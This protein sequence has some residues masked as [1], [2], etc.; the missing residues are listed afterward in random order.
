M[1]IRFFLA[2]MAHNM[3]E[4][5]S[6]EDAF[7]EAALDYD[8]EYAEYEAVRPAYYHPEQVGVVLEPEKSIRE[9]FTGVGNARVQRRTKIDLASDDRIASLEML[10][11]CMGALGPDGECQPFD[12]LS[13][14][15]LTFPSLRPDSDLSDRGLISETARRLFKMAFPQTD[16]RW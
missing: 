5:A 8:Q 14:L 4:G 2:F 16:G 1:N 15:V 7:I 9:W 13:L 10:S 3:M 6:I 12:P 11:R